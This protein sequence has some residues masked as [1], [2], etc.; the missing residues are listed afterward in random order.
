LIGKAAHRDEAGVGNCGRKFKS[1]TEISKIFW[2]RFA[3]IGHFG[4]GL[5]L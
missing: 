5:A 2:V 1:V 4:R 3:K